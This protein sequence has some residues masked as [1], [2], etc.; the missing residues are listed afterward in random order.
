MLWKNAESS[1]NPVSPDIQ[2]TTVYLRRNIQ[3]IA[4]R[5]DKVT[6]ETIPTM[7]Q[8]EEAELTPAEY[9][10]YIAEES[11]AKADYISMMLEVE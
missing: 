10:A 9:A 2:E 8:Y 4:E 6:G 11:S 3:E 1:V 5:K 7:Y